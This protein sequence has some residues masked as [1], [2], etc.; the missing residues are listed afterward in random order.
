MFFRP[1]S[2]ISLYQSNVW[3]TTRRLKL[4]I[5]KGSMYARDKGRL[6]VQGN[7][8]PSCTHSHAVY[9]LHILLLN[10]TCL[11]CICQH[12]GIKKNESP[13]G[14]INKLTWQYSQSF[15][16]GRS[17]W[18]HSILTVCFLFR[19]FRHINSWNG[20]SVNFYNNAVRQIGKSNTG[21]FTFQVDYYIVPVCM[22]QLSK[23]RTE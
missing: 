12:R 18:L 4:C 9:I 19:F 20:N 8:L 1:Y 5:I 14:R 23:Q 17:I 10:V 2:C 7:K 16:A 15:R 11:F 21:K 3:F 13:V 6:V 22:S